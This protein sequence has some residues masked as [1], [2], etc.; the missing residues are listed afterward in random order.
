MPSFNVAVSHTLGQEVAHNRVRTFAE[1]MQRDY[2][3][4][5][6]EMQSA[7]NSNQLDFS[8]IASGARIT[9]TLVVEEA[10]VAVSGPLPLVAALF[11]GRIEQSIRDELTKL[12]A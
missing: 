1:S 9:G 3:A 11:R 10:Q 6:R 4:H 12:L 7:W 2:A 8:F 5:V